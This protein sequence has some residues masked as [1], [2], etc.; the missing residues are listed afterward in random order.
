[1][2]SELLDKSM[3]SAQRHSDKV[4]TTS[5]VFLDIP[6]GTRGNVIYKSSLAD[7]G[8]DFHNT[9]QP[10]EYADDIADDKLDHRQL[11]NRI[12]LQERV[13]GKGN[14]NKLEPE[15]NALARPNV[16]NTGPNIRQSRLVFRTWNGIPLNN[17]LIMAL[18][19]HRKLAKRPRD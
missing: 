10:P 2:R 18:K 12:S 16:A 15:Q 14:Q 4:Q 9:P 19:G 8:V 17:V 3:L 7:T 13:R 11:L 5:R 1:M 6:V